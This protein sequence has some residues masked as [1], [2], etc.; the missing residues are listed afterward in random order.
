[1]SDLHNN[2]RRLFKERNK[3]WN[4]NIEIFRKETNYGLMELRHN[5]TQKHL[6][7]MSS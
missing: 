2:M 7:D 4:K 5:M 6:K 3:T 1:M